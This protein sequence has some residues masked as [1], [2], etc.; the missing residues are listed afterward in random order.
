V[1]IQTTSTGLAHR[2]AVDNTERTPL[3]EDTPYYGIDE[4]RSDGSFV[5][6]IRDLLD[7]LR[8]S[9]GMET[10]LRI[11]FVWPSSVPVSVAEN[12]GAIVEEALENIRRHGFATKV[13]IQLGADVESVFLVL[14]DEARRSPWSRRTQEQD[15]ALWAIQAR[16]VQLAAHVEVVESEGKGSKLRVVLPPW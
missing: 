10:N 13:G 4:L 6:K 7:H 12:L 15:E 16:A 14:R 3:V 2:P 5:R 11:S 1:M 9:T 8:A